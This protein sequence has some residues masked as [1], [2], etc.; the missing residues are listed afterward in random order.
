MNYFTD[1]CTKQYKNRYNFHNICK[2][3]EEFGLKCEWH[4]FATS[5]GKSS[6]DGIGGTVKRSVARASLQRVY[7]RQILTPEDMF[8]YCIENLS[9]IKFFYT[10]HEDIDAEAK[11]LNERYTKSIMIPGT[12][13]YHKFVPTSENKIKVFE[14]SSDEIGEEKFI[15]KQDSKSFF[16]NS[17][18]IPKNGDFV[19][20]KYN[21]L[22]W[23]GLVESYDDEFDDFGISY[24]YPPGF[25]KYYYF[26]ESKDFCHVI[27]DNILG[28]L[29]SPNLKTGTTRIQ[30]EFNEAELKQ[31]MQL[32]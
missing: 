26:P 25:C 17:T 9:N 6:C 27:P 30:Y 2:H 29:T 7:E 24:L 8:D 3:F 18:F 12:R 23:I 13:K 16:Q 20:S 10:T 4:F 19:V 15:E 32:N 22:K 14:I 1:E 31:I 21:Q 28:V 11:I 5:H